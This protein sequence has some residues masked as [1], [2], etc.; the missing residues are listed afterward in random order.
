MSE[1]VLERLNGALGG[2]RVRRLRVQARPGRAGLIAAERDFALVLQ[3][4]RDS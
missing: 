2:R 1:R 3:H 4:F